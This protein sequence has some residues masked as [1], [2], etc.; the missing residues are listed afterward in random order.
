MV[1]LPRVM[2]WLV[3]GVT[4]WLVHGPLGVAQPGLGS[5]GW[6]WLCRGLRVL[7]VRLGLVQVPP[8]VW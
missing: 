6:S 5:W 4:R 8:R 3:L 7:G 1:L 2:G